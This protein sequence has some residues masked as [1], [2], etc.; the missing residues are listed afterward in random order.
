MTRDAARE[1]W[2][3]TRWSKSLSGRPS[4]DTKP[5]LLLRS[6]LHRMGLRFRVHRRIPNSRLTVDIILPRYR[7]AVQVFGCFWHGHGCSVG[8]RKSPEGPNAAAWIAKRER[9]R[10]SDKRGEALLL[11]AGISTVVV[12]ECELREGAALIAARIAKL[13]KQKSARRAR[14]G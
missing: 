13:I 11:Q 12:W 4:R 7:I 6:A 10:E 9:V 3:T 1:S 5:E 2:I 14:E 8:G